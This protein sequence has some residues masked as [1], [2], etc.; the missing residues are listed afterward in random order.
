MDLIYA[1]KNKID[2]GVMKDFSLDLAYGSGENNFE[3]TV[4]TEN[5]VC[6][7][8]YFIYIEGTEYGGV[9]D[10]I[11]VDTVNSAL[12]YKGRTWHGILNSKI[13]EP[14]SGEDYYIVSGDAN[15]VIGTLISRLGLTALFKANTASSGK[16]LN[17]YQ[18][19]RY[20]AGYDGL[21]DMLQTVGAKLDIKFKDDGYVYLSALAVVDYSSDELDSDHVSFKIKKTYN[22]VNHLVCLGQGELAERTVI[23]LYA[24]ASGNISQTQTFTGIDEN[25]S[26]YNYPNVES[27]DDLL[28]EGEKK[29]KELNSAD[30]VD[31]NLDDTYMFDVG[32]ILAA[33]DDITGLHITRRVTKKIVKIDKD[34]VT[35]NYKIGE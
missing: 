27:A 17:N 2:I 7:E 3:L 4:T 31:V 23:H 8:D 16:T 19:K 22:P 25:A 13:I 35:V 11:E 32:D 24:D 12:K 6:T 33:T 5:N 1:N 9:I 10:A 15:T 14:D 28:R 18:F 20:V 30:E 21:L 29:L 34:T 26:V